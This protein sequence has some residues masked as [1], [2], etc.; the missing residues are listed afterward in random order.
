M[1]E[2]NV[3]DTINCNVSHIRGTACSDKFKVTAE[4]ENYK[5][6]VLKLLSPHSPHYWHLTRDSHGSSQS[7]LCE[8]ASP[9]GG[10]LPALGSSQCKARPGNAI[11]FLS[12]SSTFLPLSSLCKFTPGLCGNA[13]THDLWYTLA[14]ILSSPAIAPLSRALQLCE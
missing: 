4:R 9:R 1:L 2:Y 10:G 5:L 7:C 6:A 14:T 13:L 8:H 11:S 12:P 3:W